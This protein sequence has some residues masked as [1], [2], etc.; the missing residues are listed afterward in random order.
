ML[1]SSNVF[2]HLFLP[3]LLAVYFL[4]PNRGRNYVLL[5]AS[6]LFYAWG[7]PALVVLMLVSTFANY[8]F[9]LQIERQ[10]GTPLARWTLAFAVVLNLGMLVGFK[11]AGFLTEVLNGTLHWFGQSPLPVPQIVLPIGIS[12]YT[13]QAMSYVIDVFRGEVTA[14]KSPTR[15]ALYISLFPQLIAGPIVRYTQIAG[16]L[17]HRE[18]S[19]DAF[20]EGV[21]RFIVG[22]GKKM[23]IANAMAA[24]ADGI[25][26]IPD[27]KLSFTVAWL[28]I[29][30]YTLQ[31]YFDFSG[32]SD[33]AIGLGRMFGFTFPENFNYP[34]ISQSITE[35]WRRWHL[36]LSSWF[37]DY[38]YIPLGG[39]RCSPWRNSFNLIVVFLLCG[40]WHGASWNFLIWGAWHGGFLMLERRGLGAGLAKFWRPFRHTYLLFIVMFGWV[41]FRANTWPHAI[42]YFKALMGGT[43][44]TNAEFHVHLYLDSG[45]LLAL[46]AAVV[47]AL[48]VARWLKF[49]ADDPANDSDIKVPGSA[50][51]IGGY[52]KVFALALVLIASSAVLAAGTHNP[53]IYF[54]F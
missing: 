8:L 34:Y 48:P 40:L 7:E 46:A 36:S 23:L 4:C 18:E 15:V 32:Y 10:R 6:L 25:F 38:L 43:T 12:F 14:E 20:V 1:F 24:V 51:L 28:G 49:T 41:F 54:R 52:A 16:E 30:C 9:G 50:I 44:L 33:M 19:L 45:M 11:Y 47:G 27:Q 2:L 26:D 21:S 53:F 17:N 31:I 13:F 42:S 22:L 29:L 3:V 5:T 39:N 37:R 35:F